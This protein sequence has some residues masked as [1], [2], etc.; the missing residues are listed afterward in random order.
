MELLPI[1][2]NVPSSSPVVSLYLCRG[3]HVKEHLFF[4]FL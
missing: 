1:Y 2:P 3:Q 4:P